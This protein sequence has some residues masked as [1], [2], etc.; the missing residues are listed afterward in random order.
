MREQLKSRTRPYGLFVSGGFLDMW[1]SNGLCR[2]SLDKCTPQIG[3]LAEKQGLD[4]VRGCLSFKFE[5]CEGIRTSCCTCILDFRFQ[6]SFL[7][8]PSD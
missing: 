4:A 5:A 8:N 2:V 1:N 7:H 6:P 3:L